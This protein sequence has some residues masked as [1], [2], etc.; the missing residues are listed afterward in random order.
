MKTIYSLVFF[1]FLFTFISSYSYAQTVENLAKKSL[2]QNVWKKI[3]LD[4]S[5]NNINRGVAFFKQ[6]TVCNAE[7]TV[8][9]KLVNTNSF[10]VN[11]VVQFFENGPLE[12]ILVKANSEL[13]GSCNVKDSL[14]KLL[15]IKIPENHKDY[16]HY[17]IRHINVF[18]A[19]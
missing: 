4:D 8:L 9:I 15:V 6:K 19:K 11:V 18:E 7:N 5:G 10:P 14:A 17:I 1:S 3:K 2:E 12:T 13:E 16:F